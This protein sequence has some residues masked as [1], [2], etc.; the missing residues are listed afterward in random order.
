MARSALVL[1]ASVAVKWYSGKGELALQQALSIRNSHL[2]EITLIIVPDLFYY[3]VANAV[4]QKKHIPTA[5]V[6]SVV[7]A[8]FSLCLQ[9]MPLD[10][11]LLTD[12]IDIARQFNITIYDACYTAIAKNRNCPL[13]TANPRHH[14]P[15]M[16]CRVIPIED[17]QP[18]D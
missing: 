4:S 17:W 8:M 5:V 1:D 10:A 14:K 15:G 2:A 12:S 6:Q 16:G 9:T 3:E 18:V 11:E 13:V 7:A